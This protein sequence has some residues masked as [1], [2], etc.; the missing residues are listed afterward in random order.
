MNPVTLAV[1]GAGLRGIVYS[2]ATVASGRGRVVAVA[3]PDP[4]RRA[5]FAQRFGVPADQCFADWTDLAAAGRVAD[6]VVISTRQTI[7]T[8]P[9]SCWSAPT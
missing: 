1:V 4:V 2:E 9:R 7:C 8:P 6:A 3:E 5:R